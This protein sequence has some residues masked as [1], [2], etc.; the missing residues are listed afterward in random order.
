MLGRRLYA[1]LI[2]RGGGGA[3]ID[4]MLRI[5]STRAEGAVRTLTWKL[6][7]H[8]S[9]LGD[10]AFLDRVAPGPSGLTAAIL[11]EELRAAPELRAALA[12]DAAVRWARE[13]ERLATTPDRRL[14]ALLDL[15]GRGR[16]RAV[17][18]YGALRRRRPAVVIE[19]GCFTGWDTTLM[20]LAL[21][22]NGHGHLYTID[23]PG[24]SHENPVDASFQASLPLG[25]LP[26]DLEPGFLVPDA[27]RDR[28]TLR[29]GD[30]RR[31]LPALL[32]ELSEPVDMFFHDSEHSYP[33]MIWEYSTVTPYLA[34]GALLASDDVSFN[35]AFLDYCTGVGLP[36]LMHRDNANVGAA[37]W[38]DV[39]SSA[40]T[41][42]SAAP[43]IR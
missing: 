43:A 23:L 10:D 1:R 39:P 37:L 19:T 11:F 13:D 21:A 27:L 22:R 30:A 4:D 32:A 20:L 18:L 28:W 42:P 41:A 29:L 15:D 24:Y 8:A 2:Q 31:L 35:T 25:G 26:R 14:G 7:R 33:H 12:S 16:A 40:A 36:R 34:S 17:L 9:R 5:A 38:A 6:L 3:G